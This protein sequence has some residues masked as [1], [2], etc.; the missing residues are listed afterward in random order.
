MKI[1][2]IPALKHLVLASLLLAGFSI[3]TFSSNALPLAVSDAIG[4]WMPASATSGGTDEAEAA[5]IL[6][7]LYNN[8]LGPS[9]TQVDFGNGNVKMVTFTRTDVAPPILPTDI[10]MGG[11]VDYEYV[12]GKFGNTSYLWY[13]A[14]ILPATLPP[15]A[16]DWAD[17]QN[18]GKDSGLSH[19]TW[20]NATAVPDA[21][22]TATLLG[23]GLIVFEGLCRRKILV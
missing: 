22:M 21:G 1:P 4:Y 23:L 12:L 16:P 11:D 7:G 20:L 3:G 6:V 17:K 19:T 14:G 10:T 5:I 18:P 15:V 13:V 2:N 9:S 8:I